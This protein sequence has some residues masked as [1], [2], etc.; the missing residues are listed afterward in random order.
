MKAEGY[1]RFGITQHTDLWHEK[2][3]KNP[4]HQYGVD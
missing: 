4:K 1:S 2:E 3:A